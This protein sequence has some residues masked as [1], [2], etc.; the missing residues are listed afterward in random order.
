[1]KT[2]IELETDPVAAIHKRVAWLVRDGLL[3]HGAAVDVQRALER[4]LAES[5]QDRTA[6]VALVDALLRALDQKLLP[7]D[8][9]TVDEA[10]GVARFH[11][12]TLLELVA[13]QLVTTETRM[14]LLPILGS[15]EAWFPESGI[16][17][18]RQ[19]FTFTP[20]DRRRGFEF[21][22][23]KGRDF[24]KRNEAVISLSRPVFL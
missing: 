14:R 18:Y 8:A 16:R 15:I 9:Y 23:A 22:L 2:N 7:A 5:R 3:T 10:Q 6:V 24:L 17:G 19:R 1:M 13:V 21:D 11:C 4:G 20:Y 12:R